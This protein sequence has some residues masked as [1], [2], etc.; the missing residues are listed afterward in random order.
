MHLVRFFL[1]FFEIFRLTILSKTV[2]LILMTL[3]DIKELF[4][5]VLQKREKY[6]C[7]IDFF[8]GKVG[9]LLHAVIVK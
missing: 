8:F 9:G 7:L 3:H 1:E 5:G 6:L 2:E 4:K